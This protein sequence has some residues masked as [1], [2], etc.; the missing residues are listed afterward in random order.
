MNYQEALTYIEELTEKVGS[1]YSI[2]EV[3]ALSERAGRPERK[4]KMIH[5]AGT[6]GKG[7]VS[8]DIGNI[9]A[10]SGYTVGKYVSPT[11][12]EY[13]E[14][15]QKVS[16]NGEELEVCFIPEEM[17]AEKLT[18]LREYCEKMVED[19]FSHPSAFEVETILAFLAFQ[20]WNVDYAIIE[21]GLGGR[22]DAT[23]IVERPLQCIITSLSLEHQQILG[24]SIMKIAREKYGIIKKH[25]QVISARTEDC[26][27]I[28]EEQVK[29]KNAVLFPVAEDELKEVHFTTEHT[30]FSYRGVSYELKQLGTFQI[31]NAL[32]AIES[33]LRLKDTGADKITEISI[34]EGLKRSHWKGR[35]DVISQNPYIIA[36]GAHNPDAARRLAESLRTYYEGEKLDFVF[37]VLG[38]KDDRKMLEYLLPYMNRIYVVTPP[39]KRGLSAEK[40]KKHVDAVSEEKGIAVESMVCATVWEAVEQA[41]AR[42]EERKICVCG[43]LYLLGELYKKMEEST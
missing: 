39:V 4:L 13:R 43:S 27:E 34:Q 3:A 5:I 17:A 30:T 7:S 28:L 12:L 40:L 19:G 14:R 41:A 11:I 22:M 36:D 21:T 31:E 2:T 15:I 10:M 20:E 23:N 18:K 29:R 8:N 16:K 32:L 25:A 42:A 35:F 37:G 38:D 26:F 6:N 24:D 1:V 33:A 9:L